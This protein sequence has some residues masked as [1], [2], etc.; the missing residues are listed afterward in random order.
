MKGKSN[1]EDY[2]SGFNITGELRN[3]LEHWSINNKSIDL[4]QLLVIM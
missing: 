3:T 1:E 2:N 4:K